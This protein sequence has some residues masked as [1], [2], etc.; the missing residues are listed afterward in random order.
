MEQWPHC[1]LCVCVCACVYMYVCMYVYLLVY[2]PM[3]PPK[4]N[5]RIWY[6]NRFSYIVSYTNMLKKKVANMPGKRELKQHSHRWVELRKAILVSNY[7]LRSL[8]QNHTN[9]QNVCHLHTV[10]FTLCT[11]EIIKLLCTFQVSLKKKNL[12]LLYILYHT[13]VSVRK[14]LCPSTLL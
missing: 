8:P 2:L 4:Q 12:L 3:P 7:S 1:Y 14:L 10:I 5:K 13:E 11:P 9:I 6:P